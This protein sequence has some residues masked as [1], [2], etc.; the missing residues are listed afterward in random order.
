VKRGCQR[1]RKRGGDDADVKSLGSWVKEK[2]RKGVLRKG[3]DIM[4]SPW[5]STP[6]I[7]S[8]PRSVLVYRR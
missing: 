6:N 2:L 4:G 1:N 5:Y 3:E 7:V 8:F